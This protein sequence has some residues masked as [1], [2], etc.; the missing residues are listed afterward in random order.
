M[1]ASTNLMIFVQYL[2]E[3]S[4]LCAALLWAVATVL[5]ARLGEHVSA[6]KLNLLKNLLATGMLL[7]TLWVGGSIL[8]AVGINAG[9]LFLLSGAVGIGIGDT[10]YFGALQYIGARRAILLL[11]LSPPITAL[12]AL[13]LLGE[14][15]SP[16]A[17]LGIAITVAGVAWVITERVAGPRGQLNHTGRGV[18]YGLV[19]VLGQSIGSILARMVF[20]ENPVSPLAGAIL[21]VLGGLFIVF[22]CLPFDP[23]S[24]FGWGGNRKQKNAWALLVFAVFIGTYLG[25]W[26]QQTSLKYSAAGIAQTLFMTSPLFVLPLAALQGEHISWRAVCG[27]IVAVGGIILLFMP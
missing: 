7:V 9:L 20:L 6:L 12:I 21:R 14:T 24:A 22:I 11:V 26:L 17:W 23:G 15:L 8:P 4:A 16:W 10:A 19:A 25:I 2:G 13:G 27:A 5:Y 3:A 1:E 18:I